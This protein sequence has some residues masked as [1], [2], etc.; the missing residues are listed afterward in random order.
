MKL[1]NHPNLEQKI[2][3]KQMTV[4]VKHMTI[5]ILSLRLQC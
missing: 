1:F 5:E 3:L 2:E 4:D